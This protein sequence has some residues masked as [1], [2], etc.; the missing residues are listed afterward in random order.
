LVDED[1]DGYEDI[2]NTEYQM[3]GLISFI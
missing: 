1:E 3:I 2:L